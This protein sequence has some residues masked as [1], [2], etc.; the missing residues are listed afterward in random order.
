[1]TS[2]LLEPYVQLNT[3]S[4]YI[5][6]TYSSTILDL[7]LSLPPPSQEY[8]Y[9][10]TPTLGTQRSHEHYVTLYLLHLYSNT[11]WI[12]LLIYLCNLIAGYKAICCYPSNSISISNPIS[13]RLSTLKMLK[14]NTISS[15][16]SKL[17]ISFRMISEKESVF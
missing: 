1:M 3:V 4:S 9:L 5:L 17:L 8:P 16:T 10:G 2:Y 7:P 14:N 13:S 6:V 15:L 11:N 12:K